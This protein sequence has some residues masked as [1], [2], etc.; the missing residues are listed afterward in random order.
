DHDDQL[1]TREIFPLNAA[2]SEV[3]RRFTE[4]RAKASAAAEWFPCS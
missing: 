2:I 3:Q 4:Q 1:V